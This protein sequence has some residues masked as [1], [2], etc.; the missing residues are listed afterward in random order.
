V[1][2]FDPATGKLELNDFTYAGSNVGSRREFRVEP[3]VHLPMEIESEGQTLIGRLGDISMSGAGFYIDK[4]DSPELKRGAVVTIS[5]H[6]PDGDIRLPATLRSIEQAGAGYRL[7]VEFTENVPE[8]ATILRYI[9]HRQAEIRNEV[10]Q[11]Y[12]ALFPSNKK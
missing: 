12:E 2:F 3:A 8:K 6:L 1:T 11:R 7:A 10:Q 5:L 9:N 4:P